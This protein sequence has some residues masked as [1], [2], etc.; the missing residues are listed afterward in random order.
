MCTKKHSDG[1]DSWDLRDTHLKHRGMDLS[2]K[3]F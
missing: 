2:D 3:A 1:V